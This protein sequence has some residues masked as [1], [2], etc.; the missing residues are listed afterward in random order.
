MTNTW[1]IGASSG[2]GEALAIELAKRGETV[3]VTARNA[4]AIEAV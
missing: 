3:C 2:I 1:I 4:Q